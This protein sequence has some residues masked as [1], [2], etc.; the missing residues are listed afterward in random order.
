MAKRRARDK[1]TM[2]P[3]TEPESIPAVEEAAAN[4]RD[5][6]DSRMS[7]TEEEADAKKKLIDV[8]KEHGVE[9]YQFGG[10]EVVRTHEETDNVKV[11]KLKATPRD[12]ED[13][14]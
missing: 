1:Q 8:M 13:D 12:E 14:E 9:K 4:Y 5:I 7:L 10:Y 6:R 11:R 2:I 3:G